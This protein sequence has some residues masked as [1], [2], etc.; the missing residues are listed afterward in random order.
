MPWK[1]CYLL[2]DNSNYATEDIN[3]N[4]RELEHNDLKECLS[5]DVFLT[6]YDIL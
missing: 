5:T 6:S 2:N 1:P 4:Y 3:M